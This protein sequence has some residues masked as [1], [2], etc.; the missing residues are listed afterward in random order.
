MYAQ[1]RLLN[2]WQKKLTYS[3]HQ[4]PAIK[5]GA[6]VRVPLQKRTEYALVEELSFHSS[7]PG[8]RDIESVINLPEEY[9][10]SISRAANHY[11]L[12]PLTLYRRLFQFL[13]AHEKRETPQQSFST[14]YEKRTITLTNHQQAIVDVLLH[15]VGNKKFAPSL[16]YGV[17]GSGKTEI[18]TVLLEKALLHGSAL[19][20]VPEVAV[21]G[22][23]LIRLRNHFG[24]IVYGIHTGTPPSERRAVL[25]AVARGERAI[26]VGVHIPIMLPVQELALIIV[27]EEHADGFV[28]K[29]HPK[30][31][32]RDFALMRAFDAKIPIVL[33][34]ATPSAH[35]LMS[36]REKN[37]KLFHLS[38]RF[39]GAFPTIR[40]ILLKKD[41][42]RRASFWMSRELETALRER[43]ARGEQAILFIN[44]RGYSFFI[45]CGDCSAVSRCIQCSVSLTLHARHT[46]ECHYCG[47]NIPEPVACASCGKEE[48][49]KKGVGT[50]KIVEIVAKLFPTAR[51]ARGDLD[52]VSQKKK[53]YET[54]EGFKNHT[55][56][57]LVGTQTITKGF[58]FPR[59]TLVGVIWADSSLSFPDYRSL[60]RSVQQLIQVSGRAG[61]ACDKSEVIIQSI[62]DHEIFNNLDETAYLRF[63]EQELIHRKALSYPPFVK[64]AEFEIRA[65]TEHTVAENAQIIAEEIRALCATKMGTRVLGPTKPPIDKVKNVFLRTI[66]VKSSSAQQLVSIYTLCVKKYPQIM[67]LFSPSP[68]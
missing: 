27:D 28:E 64:M 4:F 48:L 66:L 19:F 1:V 35:A 52:T 29:Q 22:E 12:E 67:L 47:Y 36:V 2:G 68:L 32:T 59:V 31:S 34:S 7:T 42:R 55:I 33:G 8:I 44:R 5:P 15:D 40:H 53:W 58:D 57:I 23:M 38:E 9:T 41:L 17:T 45:Q 51:I 20:L 54:V 60:E 26:I 3:A 56:D 11:G 24:S 50:E 10:R 39:R 21:A 30:I 25:N 61:R 62:A 13:A 18:Y 65:D 16:V 63:M 46:L 14:D 37:W 49:I 43:L 6:L